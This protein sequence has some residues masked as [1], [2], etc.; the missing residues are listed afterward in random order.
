M[1][2]W[3]V[4]GTAIESGFGVGFMGG[5]LADGCTI[6]AG[7]SGVG[8]RSI[9]AML[10]LASIVAGAVLKSAALQRRVFGK[11]SLVPAESAERRSGPVMYWPSQFRT[12]SAPN[13]IRIGVRAALAYYFKL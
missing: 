5:V 1:L 11:A 4:A 3:S 13:R 8:M 12:G 2:F 9:A 6:G 7:L 10:A